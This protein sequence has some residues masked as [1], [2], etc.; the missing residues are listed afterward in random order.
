M[1]WANQERLYTLLP[2]IYRLRDHR[3]G[4]PLRA[5][6]SII[7]NEMETLE[8]DIDGLYANWFI[9][10]TAEWL[11][12]YIGDLLGVRNLHTIDSA[13]IYSLRAYV[14]N[15]LRYR[16]GKGTPAVLEQLA[17][18]ITGWEARVVEFFQLL[19]TT[20]HLNHLRRHNL[21]T[22]DLR[23]ANALELLDSPFDATAHTAEVRRIRTRQGRYAISHVGLFLWRLQSYPLQHLSPRPAGGRR[24]RLN[25]L[26][27]DVP[28]FN[29][30]EREPSI[31]HLATER[32]VPQAIRRRAIAEEKSAYL[33]HVEPAAEFFFSGNQLTSEQ[34]KICHLESWDDPGWTPPT[35][36]GQE[37]VA[38]DPV[39]GRFVI[40]PGTPVPDQGSLE[41]STTYGF[42]AD[43]G[44][45]P[46]NRNLTMEQS[47]E[48][49]WTARVSQ[50]GSGDFST[51]QAAVA[52]WNAAAAASANGLEGVIAIT[53]NLT[54]SEELTGG[55]S[56]LLP[57]H[58]R[59]LLTSARPFG[60]ANVRLDANGARA[61]LQ[62]NL[63]IDGTAPPSSTH[64]GS[65]TVDGL[66]IEGEVRIRQGNL[67]ECNLIHTTV[68]PGTDAL[69]APSSSNPRLHVRL[70]R[71]ICGSIRLA[72]TVPYLTIEE[73]IIDGDTGPDIIAPGAEVSIT[74][75]TLFGAD[76][77]LTTPA[78]GRLEAS[79]SIFMGRLHVERRQ[80][81]CVRF[82]SLPHQSRTP[83][84]YRCQ[85]DLALDGETSA[86]VRTALRHRLRPDFTSTLYGHPGYAQLS[87]SCAVEIRTGAEDGSE[88]GVFSFLKQPQRESNLWAA[89]EEYLPF[90]LEAGLFFVN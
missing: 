58:C 24:F 39:N 84:R 56:I 48:G 16:Q 26:G 44:G 38:L 82:C 67:G 37:K 69:T 4:E 31:R 35:P 27:L 81:G 42:S 12:P 8:S 29:R 78:L 52:A 61:H 71:S 7:Q 68:L 22:P 75:S 20:Q 80:Q 23:R 33:G 54:Y 5:L 34:I 17:D 64:P 53:D 19:A 59:L 57:A 90:G 41:V 25:P 87:R 28:L 45:G 36:K 15:T 70:H 86:T 49:K 66:L 47:V 88:M 13:G 14:A 55:D 9:E 43:V 51:L 11:I 60:P 3:Q 89:L 21:R 74:R 85:P 10:T 65:I 18:D 1:S 83:R 30:P 76:D 77:D 50:D 32:N 40:L 73:S 46:Y 79:E 63:T 6:L 62:G 2:A 72:A